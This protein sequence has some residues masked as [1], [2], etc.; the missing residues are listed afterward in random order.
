M[1][2]GSAICGNEPSKTKGSHSGPGQYSSS[3]VRYCT[4]LIMPE[5][6]NLQPAH[7]LPLGDPPLRGLSRRGHVAS[8]HEV[9]VT[10]PDGTPLEVDVV[11]LDLLDRHVDH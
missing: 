10:R 2:P 4:A 8:Q 11:L 5:P 6:L 3:S 1:S 7:E 9:L